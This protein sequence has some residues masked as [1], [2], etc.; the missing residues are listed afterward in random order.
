MLVTWPSLFTSAMSKLCL[1]RVDYNLFIR[2]SVFANGAFRIALG[3]MSM[4]T[5][6]YQFINRPFWESTGPKLQ[7]VSSVYCK[8]YRQFRFFWKQNRLFK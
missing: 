3:C 4:N 5:S 2:L 6:N 1:V 8:D 7:V